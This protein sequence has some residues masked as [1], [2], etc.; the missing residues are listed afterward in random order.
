MTKHLLSICARTSFGVYLTALAISDTGSLLTWAYRWIV[1]IV[2]D[3]G[4]H[5]VE[6]K[7]DVG[8]L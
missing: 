1:D 7:L 5:H 4:M 3:R 2:V 6:C 8:E